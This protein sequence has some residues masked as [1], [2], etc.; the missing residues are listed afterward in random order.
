MHDGAEN[1]LQL[2]KLHLILCHSEEVHQ[3]N[4]ILR[5]VSF[6]AADGLDGLSLFFHLICT[7]AKIKG[8]KVRGHDEYASGE[9]GQT[10]C[11]YAIGGRRWLVTWFKGQ[12][13]TIGQFSLVGQ[14]L[15][16]LLQLSSVSNTL[17]V[18]FVFK[19]KPREGVE[20]ISAVSEKD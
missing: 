8:N 18:H 10:V 19:K 7:V 5:S 11:R 14:L 1:R 17:L 3:L 4:F 2:A 20:D 13:P 6:D 12:L 9:N 15:F 16:L